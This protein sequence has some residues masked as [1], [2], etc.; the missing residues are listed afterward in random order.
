MNTQPSD[1]M[2]TLYSSVIQLHNLQAGKL[3]RNTG[4]YANAVFYGLIEDVD[5]ELSETLHQWNG[6]KPFTISA[7]QGLPKGG[8]RTPHLKAGWE[9]WLRV[10]TLGNRI[11][12][13]L[14]QHFL[15]GKSQAKIRLGSLNFGISQ[16]LTTPNSHTW[17][18]YVEAEKL[19]Q[20]AEPTQTLTLDFTSPTRFH[21]KGYYAIMP[22]PKLVF[23]SLATK[24][25]AFLEPGLD[26]EAIEQVAQKVLVTSYN[27]RSRTWYWKRRPRKGFTGRCTYNLER[28]PSEE[29]KRFSALADFALYG[30][31]GG[32]TTQGM[33][34]C[35]RLA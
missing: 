12:Q 4:H 24:W 23:G 18:D 11:F 26:R 28:L 25:N 15:L 8:G 20:E 35:R 34:Q 21:I 32:K 31:V 6:R 33:G 5:P 9:C 10:T 27:L 16:V 14:M 3:P 30:G 19:L 17:A 1:P 13:P 29:Q 7:L 2:T 22:M